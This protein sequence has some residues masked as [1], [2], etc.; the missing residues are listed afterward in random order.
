MNKSSSLCDKI[1]N[2]ETSKPFDDS[3]AEAKVK[4][5]DK[6]KH[7]QGE[8]TSY[9]VTIPRIQK[10]KTQKK[11]NTSSASDALSRSYQHP[12]SLQVSNGTHD[13]SHQRSGVSMRRSSSV[14]CKRI[15]A[16]RGST[17]SSDDS[18]FS[19]GS[20]NTSAMLT[21]FTLEQ[22]VQNMHLNSS[23]GSNQVPKQ[24]AQKSTETNDPS[25]MPSSSS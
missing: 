2:Q 21:G 17:S 9:S 22:A 25:N 3:N 8:N 24:E 20:P 6:N 16:E 7:L 11:L 19:P 13:F 5:I 4:T 15:T 18:G 14:P 1:E 12:N 23:E 10:S